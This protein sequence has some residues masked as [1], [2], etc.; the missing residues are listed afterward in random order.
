MAAYVRFV[1]GAGARVVPLIYD[2]PEEV[3]IEKLGKLNGVLFP[4]GG[5]DYKDIGQLIVNHAKEMNDK[6]DFFPLWG[7]CLGFERLALFTATDSHILQ[8]YGAKHV[9]LPITFVKDP[10]T[11]KMFCPMGDESLKLQEG[12][13]TLNSHQYS[14]PQETFETD[15]GLKEMWDVTSLSYDPNLKKPF[16]A[17]IEGK[18]YPFMATQF[19]P[20]KVT[21]AWNDNYGIN[22]SWQSMELNMFFGQQ[23]LA[24]ARNSKHTFGNFT[25]TTPYLIDNYDKFETTYYAAELYMFK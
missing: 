19:H 20:E 7:T 3:T 16:V 24:M 2:E 6:G 14:I 10:R 17:T 8:H 15:P 21:Q 4:G 23:F 1:Q 5:G 12:N 11:T 13:Y 22:H 18:K 9:S 25:E